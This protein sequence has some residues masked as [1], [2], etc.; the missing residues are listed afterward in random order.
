[1]TLWIRVSKRFSYCNFTSLQNASTFFHSRMAVTPATQ[2][3]MPTLASTTVLIT[4]SLLLIGN[5]HSE[6]KRSSSSSSTIV[7]MERENDDDDDDALYY[8]YV[9]YIPFRKYHQYNNINMFHYNIKG[10]YYSLLSIKD[11]ICNNITAKATAMATKNIHPLLWYT[12]CDAAV[13]VVPIRNDSPS[14]LPHSPHNHSNNTTGTR[15]DTSNNNNKN[16]KNRIIFL[17][18]GSSTGCPRPLCPLLFSDIVTGTNENSG[19][20]NHKKNIDKCHDLTLTA[21]LMKLRE[22][23]FD[24]CRTSIFASIGDPIHNKDYRNNPSLLISIDAPTTPTATGQSSP[25]ERYN[26]IIDVGKT[27]REGAIR[28]LPKYHIPTIDA[29]VLT[30]QHMDA[31]GGLDD[32]RGF[33]KYHWISTTRNDNSDT[34]KT[35]A[36]AAITSTTT[37]RQA[38]P[39]PLFV[40]DICRSSLQDQ[41]PWLLPKQR[42]PEHF[43]SAN[44]PSL[45]PSS[46]SPTSD[47]PIAIERHVASFDVT[48]FEPFQSFE[49][50]PGFKI[51][52]L[53]LIHGEDLI[54]YGF[55]FTLGGTMNV[56]YLSD[57][58]RMLPETLDYIQNTLPQPIHVLIL[59]ALLIDSSNPVHYCLPQSL[60]LIQ[61]LQ[62][63]QTYLVGMNCDSFGPHEERNEQL[64]N[65]YGN[66][67]LAHDGLVIDAPTND[68][69]SSDE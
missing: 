7:N 11:T 57:I 47:P 53:P 44:G 31:V 17:G 18:S 6:M 12:Q 23:M 65:D 39:M 58:S 33:Q 55:A 4:M 3:I 20:N 46:S 28:W 9:D 69:A 8:R 54:S 27:F 48:I 30:H 56:V 61:Q 14:T 34:T 2:N 16:N 37:K 64:R 24:Q 51:I 19:K 29:I 60:E 35:A 49:P 43:N 38:I 66:V 68:A 45:S 41:F 32:V 63:L 52:P 10:L 62:P 1:M 42:S 15:H 5:I 59:D 40:S 67:Q 21:E 50:V 25:P 13:P 36:A 22:R 26:I